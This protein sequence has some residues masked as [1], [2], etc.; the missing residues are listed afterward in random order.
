[1]ARLARTF[2][3]FANDFSDTLNSAARAVHIGTGSAVYLTKGVD[4]VRRLD[5]KTAVVTGGARGIG[6]A[7]CEALA[8]EG[9]RV[10]IA[11]LADGSAVA[12]RIEAAGGR[13]IYVFTDVSSADSVGNLRQT[14]FE[15]FGPADILVNN[16]AIFAA[17]SKKSFLEITAAE[18]DEVMAVN[19]RGPFHCCRAFAPGMMEKGG[20]KI[21]NTASATVFKGFAGAL[22]YVSSKG[23]LI[24]MTRSLAREL[25]SYGICVNAI[26]P[27]LTM[28]EG[29]LAN[30]EWGGP[31]AEATVNTRAFK[32]EQTPRDIV[33]ALL[34][35]AS[36]DSDFMTGQTIVVDGGAVMR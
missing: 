25:G 28:S 6:A 34:F 35:L 10:I 12:A 7:F 21:I 1:L 2:R 24:A 3:F 33:G 17:L 9:A 19:L 11:D 8:S 29:V 4:I 31:A 23:G 22:H 18:W 32:R 14:S 20:G 13:A 30:P 5:G 36:S 16:A 27:G 26:A 15:A